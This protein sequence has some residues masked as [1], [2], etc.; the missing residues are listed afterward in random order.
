[1]RS[2]AS[3]TNLGVATARYSSAM[4]TLRSGTDIRINIWRR[5]NALHAATN[6]A[7]ERTLSGALRRFVTRLSVPTCS[8]SGNHDNSSGGLPNNESAL[9]NGISSHRCRI[10]LSPF[11]FSIGVHVDLPGEK[12]EEEDSQIEKKRPVL[13]I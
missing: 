2:T 13:D 12:R 8:I 4:A 1:M 5:T 10:G 6:S 9:A 7:G 11:K 3:A